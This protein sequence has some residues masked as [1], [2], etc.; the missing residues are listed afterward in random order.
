MLTSNRC[1]LWLIAGIVL[2]AFRAEAAEIT[3]YA[4]GVNPGSL[5]IN[6]VET[7]LE[8]GPIYGFRLR[9]DFVPHFGMEHTLGFSGDYLFPT[10]IS[11]VT[12]AKGFVFNSNLILDLPMRNLV[13]YVTAGVGL[14]HQYGSENLPLG[15]QFAFNYGGGLKFPRLIGPLG[16]RVDAR[17]YTATGISSTNLNMFEVSGGVLFSFG[18]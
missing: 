14:V 1:S 7:A 10:N 18:R 12:D 11:A 6:G 13:P 16:L 5:S 15:T 8:S 9:T 3:A 17:G 4:G 2:F